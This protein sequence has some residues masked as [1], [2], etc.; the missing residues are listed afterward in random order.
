MSIKKVSSRYLGHKDKCKF[1]DCTCRSCLVVVERQKITAARVAHLRQQRKLEI[2]RGSSVMSNS[3]YNPLTEEEEYVLSRHLQK[4]NEEE[5]SKL[6]TYIAHAV[7]SP[8]HSRVLL[9]F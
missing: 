5:L 7:S 1:K 2:K 9:R 3:E 6:G 8:T 4:K